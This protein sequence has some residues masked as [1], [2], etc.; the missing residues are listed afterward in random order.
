VAYRGNGIT[1]REFMYAGWLNSVGLTF[2][3]TQRDHLGHRT[4]RTAEEETV[5][6]YMGSA[7]AAVAEKSNSL[8]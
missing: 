7:E 4:W 5:T 8:K 6:R 3:T 1:R 2:V